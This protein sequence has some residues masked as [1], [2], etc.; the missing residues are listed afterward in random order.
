MSV[1][2]REPVACSSAVAAALAV[3]IGFGVPITAQQASLITA[4]VVA[5]MGVIARSQV[6]PTASTQ[7]VDLAKVGKP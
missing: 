4:F 2:E 7:T 6:T 5:V 1:W 3:A